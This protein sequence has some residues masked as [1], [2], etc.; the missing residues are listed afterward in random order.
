MITKG[1]VISQIRGSNKYLVRIPYL[2]NAFKTTSEYE[3]ILS[4]TP[5]VSNSLAPEDVVLVGFEDH[6]ASKPIIL[7]KLF[8]DES[9]PRGNALFQDL[10]V[11]SSASLPANTTVGGINLFSKLNNLSKV[12]DNLQPN[13]NDISGLTV[14]EVQQT[15][16][17]SYSDNTYILTEELTQKIISGKYILKIS[18]LL[19]GQQPEVISYLRPSYVMRNPTQDPDDPVDV[20][21]YSTAFTYFETC[22][23][24]YLFVHLLSTNR[25]MINNSL[26]HTVAIPQTLSESE[27]S[28]QL[29]TGDGPIG[30]AVQFVTI[31][32][33]PIVGTGNIEVQAD[34]S[35]SLISMAITK[36]AITNINGYTPSGFSAVDGTKTVSGVVYTIKTIYFNSVNLTETKARDYM[37]YM[38]G[39]RFLPVYNYQKPQNTSLIFDDGSVWKPQFDNADGLV[40]FKVNVPYLI[41]IANLISEA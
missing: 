13:S 4:T 30:S 31:N 36:N 22:V 32:N 41:N 29:N 25:C 39:S 3:A 5:G 26:M 37:E 24:T 15:D 11:E 20:Y 38:T 35:N 8:V 1:I 19:I 10:L 16:I 18:S 28:I 21:V 33:Q 6:Q 17:E 40:L 9:N 7:G 14:Y 27:N 12:I 2:E 34:V 23:E